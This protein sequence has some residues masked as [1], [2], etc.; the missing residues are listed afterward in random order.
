MLLLLF[1]SYSDS[2]GQPSPCFLHL[3]SWCSNGWLRMEHYFHHSSSYLPFNCIHHLLL[4]HLTTALLRVL[5][6]S[7]VAGSNSSLQ[8]YCWDS[9]KASLKGSYWTFQNESSLFSMS[10]TIAEMLSGFTSMIIFWSARSCYLSFW[11]S[12]LVLW[13]SSWALCFLHRLYSTRGS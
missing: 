12:V 10:F 6:E 8:T 13:G 5:L 7:C 2:T 1:P 9:T 3:C 4:T 11:L